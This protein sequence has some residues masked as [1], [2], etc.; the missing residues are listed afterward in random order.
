M[1]D[2][3]GG[4]HPAPVAKPAAKRRYAHTRNLGEGVF[5]NDRRCDQIADSPNLIEQC[6]VAV[7]DEAVEL[8]PGTL[9][10]KLSFYPTSVSTWKRGDDG[11][12]HQ[13]GYFLRTRSRKPFFGSFLRIPISSSVNSSDRKDQHPR[14]RA[15]ARLHARL[16]MVEPVAVALVAPGGSLGSTLNSSSSEVSGMTSPP[17]GSPPCTEAWACPRAVVAQ[18]GQPVSLLRVPRFDR[19]TG[20]PPRAL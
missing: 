1:T 5:G 15:A 2:S 18:A 13:G 16:G 6:F 20:R 9:F 19:L 8:E 10:H 4:K 3:S 11:L 17:A 7:V 14:R 12:P